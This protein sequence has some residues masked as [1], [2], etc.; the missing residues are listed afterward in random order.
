MPRLRACLAQ[1]QVI[2]GCG[3]RADNDR[4]RRSLVTPDRAERYAALPVVLEIGVEC[5]VILAKAWMGSTPFLTKT[6]KNVRTEMS[7][8]VLAYNMKRMIHIFG[9]QPLIQAIR[10]SSTDLVRRLNQYSTPGIR[11]FPQPRPKASISIKLCDS[12]TVSFDL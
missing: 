7:L 8:S 3:Q 4:G 12:R 10:A 2:G 1:Q 5:S 6:L 9:V 11:V